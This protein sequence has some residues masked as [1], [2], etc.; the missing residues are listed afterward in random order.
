M[1]TAA[2]ATGARPAHKHTVGALTSR[3]AVLLVLTLFAIYTLVPPWWLL[4]TATKNKGYLFTTNGLWFSHFDLWTNIHEVFQEQDG[5]FLRWIL[6]S[7]LYS[8]GGAAVGTLVSAM[9]GYALAKYSF[10]GRG[11][12]FNIVLGAVLVPASMFALPLYLMFS[13]TH[14]VNTYWA[15]FLPSIVSPFGVYLSRVYAGAAVPDELLEAGRIDGAREAGIFWRISM[16]IMSPALVT[17]FLFQFVGI[18]NNYLL[19][20]LM[21][22]DDR[23]QPIT[24]GLANWRAEL[25]NGVP[26]SL[27]IT[28]SLLSVIP[29]LI[30]FFVLQRYWRSG[31]TA[32]SVK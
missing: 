6:N 24:V 8:I 13:A 7:V 28:G 23:L 12:V 1:T 27:T 30:A 10:R 9:A 32:G 11:L 14:L 21:L 19:P 25:N 2:H 29:L 31:L 16:P 17:I 15:V 18:W 22:S 3:A 4:V 20:V 26:Y 5:V